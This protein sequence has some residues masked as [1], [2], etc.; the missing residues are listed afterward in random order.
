MAFHF[1][2]WP[3]LTGNA[4]NVLTVDPTETFVFWGNG[5]A[6][7][8][9]LETNGTPNGAQSILNLVAGTGMNITDNGLGDITFDALGSMIIGD[10]VINGHINDILFIDASGNLAQNDFFRWIDSLES[11]IVAS[12][13]YPDG[14]IQTLGTSGIVNLGDVQGD[15]NNTAIIID[16]RNAH[17]VITNLFGSSNFILHGTT[18][19]ISAKVSEFIVTGSTYSD[20]LLDIN[21][22][23][24]IVSVG[25]F[26]FDFNG[27]QMVIND[28][29][30]TLFIG[31]G[32]DSISFDGN[33]NTVIFSTPLAAIPPAY[34]FYGTSFTVIG[35]GGVQLLIDPSGNGSFSG[36]SFF[37]F[38]NTT[39]TATVDIDTGSN[40]ATLKYVDGNQQVGYVLTSDA[41]GNATWQLNTAAA[42][43]INDPIIGATIG[44]VLFVGD[45]GMGNPVLA[46]DFTNFHYDPLTHKL[47]VTGTIDP[48]DIIFSGTTTIDHSKYQIGVRGGGGSALFIQTPDAVVSGNSGVQFELLTGNGSPADS[49]FTGGL[50][51]TVNLTTGVGGIA[52]ATRGGGTGGLMNLIGGN[53]GDGTATATSGGG[54]SINIF[55]GLPGA[56]NGGGLGS[57]GAVILGTQTG[58]EFHVTDTGINSLMP[59]NSST[60]FTIIQ[61]IDPYF[62]ID[63]T[64]GAEAMLLGNSFITSIKIGNLSGMGIEYDGPTSSGSS[65]FN[66]GLILDNANDFYVLGNI[67]GVTTPDMGVTISKNLQ[68]IIGQNL[69]ASFT[70]TVF[71]GSG[72]N[73]L[74]HNTRFYGGATTTYIITIDGLQIHYNTLVGGPFQV[75][76]TVTGGTSGATG[77]VVTDNGTNTMVVNTVAGGPFMLAETITGST[78]LAT[79]IVNN[80]SIALTD[81]YTWTDG[82]T[83]QNFV[84]TTTT[85]HSLSFGQRIEF[86]AIT[87]HTIGDNWTWDASTASQQVFSF[88]SGIGQYLIGDI[89]SAFNGTSIAIDD[90]ARTITYTALENIYTGR[91]EEA[92][93]IDVVA[94]NDLTLGLDGNAFIVTGN[95]TINA[96]TTANWQAG[97]QITL[98][99]TGTPT[100]N[101]NT[102]GG[103]GTAVLFLAGSVPLSASNNTVLGLVYDGTQ[104][105]ETFR[106]VA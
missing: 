30:N 20:G 31:A 8:I 59:V 16:D 5:A 17:Q 101:H 81:T 39:P 76:E 22:T 94:A 99:F 89:G 96:I 56:D 64:S 3:S 42:L 75:G 104:W 54:G 4:N 26:G 15:V 19:K 82:S 43:A 78:S 11:F 80:N 92:K 88:D 25:D 24:G 79:A 97:S 95:T 45:D 12:T 106:K 40:N 52:S 6:G 21:D 7:S 41:S 90:T 14:L 103:A 57:Q 51:G 47:T 102:A 1:P 83:T 2:I 67:G 55:G 74:T 27:V 36:G 35:F 10:P 38:G 49:F 62:G 61:G 18:N 23:T 44:S 28:Q 91:V 69:L 71:T 65:N 87:G 58:V 53:G 100:V 70:A 73:D 50:G 66:N 29:A 98:I 34:T 37:G 9:L 32:V 60:A 46:E 33:A 63:T 93:G 77:I 13:A 68:S 105:Q 48:T 84:L 72:A 85:F 86:S